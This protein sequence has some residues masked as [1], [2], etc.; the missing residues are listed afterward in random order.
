MRFGEKLFFLRKQRGMTQMELAEK[1][2]ISRQ[3]VSR[4]EQGVSEP[5]T[6]NLVSIGKLFDVS[7][8]AL[9]NENL[10]FQTEST[11]QVAVKENIAGDKDRYS[12]AKI[13]GIMIFAIAVVFVF[14]CVGVCQ[15]EPAPGKDPINIEDL[16]RE[17]VNTD[18]F[19]TG[20][21]PLELV[22]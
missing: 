22:D 11:V 10:Q 12:I 18:G 6:E 13:V 19:D 20:D 7:V 4:W 14:I 21:L 15:K 2:D 17:I 16:E 5:S 1:L 3:A 9:V 8:D